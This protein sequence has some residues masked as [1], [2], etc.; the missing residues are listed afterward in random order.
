MKDNDDILIIDSAFSD[1]ECASVRKGIDDLIGLGLGAE[2]N[3][4]PGRQDSNVH[5]RCLGEAMSTINLGGFHYLN[6]FNERMHGT[7]L[8]EYVGRFPILQ[9]KNLGNM[10]AKGQR[11]KPSG[12][13]HTWHYEADNGIS[14]DRILV[15]TLYLNDDFDAGETEFLYKQLRVKPKTGRFVMWPAGFLHTHRG[16]P[17]IGGDKYIMTGW[18]TD[19]DPWGVLK[20]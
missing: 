16:N 2:A 12:G 10:D 4:D 9:H 3:S 14:Y 15:W 17:P 19:L 6:L 7:F 5:F 8:P 1:D 20:A 11:T 18:I 13:F